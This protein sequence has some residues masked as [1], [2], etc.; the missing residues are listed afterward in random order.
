M[1]LGSLHAI[2]M[3]AKKAFYC[4][5]DNCYLFMNIEII[6]LC[7]V[8]IFLGFLFCLFVAIMFGD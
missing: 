3:I 5:D 1:F 6:V 8:S 2:V 7:G 4:F